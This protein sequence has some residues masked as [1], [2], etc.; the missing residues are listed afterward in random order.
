MLLIE[1]EKTR[2]HNLK[3]RVTKQV[4]KMFVISLGNLI[5]LE[6]TPQSQTVCA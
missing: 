3:Y 2:G 1:V 4:S 5:E 6:S